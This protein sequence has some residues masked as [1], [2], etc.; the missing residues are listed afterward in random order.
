MPS[1]PG[2][3]LLGDRG[4]ANKPPVL[5]PFKMSNSSNPS[6]VLPPR[7]L[8]IIKQAFRVLDAN[9]DGFISKSELKQCLRRFGIQFRDSDI[10]RALQMIGLNHD[11]SYNEYM[12]FVVAVY[13]GEYD[14]FLLNAIGYPS[15]NIGGIP[16][17]R[18]RR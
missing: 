2:C 11:V 3:W 12:K 17:R 9:H 5:T 15:A 16:R 1:S 8:Q 4:F 10:D 18:Y 14:Q 6:N 7:E 13:R